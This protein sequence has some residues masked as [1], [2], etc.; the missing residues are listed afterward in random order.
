MQHS[1]AKKISRQCV[2][3][4]QD[5]T[6]LIYDNVATGDPALP[7]WWYNVFCECILRLVK[8]DARASS[9]RQSI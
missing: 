9:E 2:L 7:A 5:L 1:M 3:A 6:D 8:R 4:A